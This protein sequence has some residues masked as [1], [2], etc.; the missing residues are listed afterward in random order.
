[1]CKK[2]SASGS[3]FSKFI[4]EGLQMSSSSLIRWSGLAALVGSVL[5][6]VL[7][8]AE[9]ALLGDQ[10]ESVAAATG[11]LIIVRASFIMAIALIILGLVGL[12][13]RQAEQT[14]VLGLIAFL[15]AF[16]GSVMVAGLQWGAAFISPWLAG[17]APELLDTE[18]SEALMAGIMLSFV[19]FALGWL[20]FGL[21]SLR[22]RALPRGAAVLLMVGAALMF[23]LLLLEL[24]GFTVVFGVALA[25]MGYAL[26]AGAAETGTRPRPAT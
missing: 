24:P 19:L 21:A 2:R 26:W 12:Y 16:I 13:A 6:V 15:V 1:M 3:C 18:P 10:A 8:V 14:G 7:D 11:A 5:L 17:V 20:L 25:W 9:F 22:A 4:K 23:V